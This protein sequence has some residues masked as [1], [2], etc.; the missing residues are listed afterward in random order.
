VTPSENWRSLHSLLCLAGITF[1]PG[2]RRWRPLIGRVA[3]TV[4]HERQGS[5]VAVPGAHNF[6]FERPE[7]LCEPLRAAVAG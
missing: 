5:S 1:P 3:R 4:R 2:A 7:L 6:S